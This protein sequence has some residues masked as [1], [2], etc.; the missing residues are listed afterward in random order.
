MKTYGGVASF[1]PG[2]TPSTYWIGGWVGPR[3]GLDDVERRKILPLPRL[4]L[5]S[6]S[7]KCSCDYSVLEKHRGAALTPLQPRLGEQEVIFRSKLSDERGR[8]VKAVTQCF[9]LKQKYSQTRHMRAGVETRL[10]SVCIGNKITF[11]IIHLQT[12]ASNDSGHSCY[13]IL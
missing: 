7:H 2:K 5:R 1:T 11:R 13:I 9:I 8:Q 4:E 6:L 10:T 3:T 12:L